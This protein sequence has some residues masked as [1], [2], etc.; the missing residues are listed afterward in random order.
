MSRPLFDGFPP[1][2]SDAWAELVLKDLKGGDPEKLLKTRTEDGLVIQAISRREHLPETLPG[3]L[4]SAGPDGSPNGWVNR[5]EIREKD[6]AAANNHAKTCL[7]RGAEELAWY[8]FPISSGSL[9][10]EA[11]ARLTAGVHLEMVPVHWLAGPLA[12]QTALLLIQEAERRGILPEKLT[13]S[14]DLDP[15][16]DIGAAW[17]DGDLDAWEDDWQKVLDLLETRL[18]GMRTLC[19]RGSMFGKAGA[20]EIQELAFSL[21][22][23]DEYL[24]RL[25]EGRRQEIAARAEVR[26]SVTNRFLVEAARLRASRVLLANLFAAHGVEGHPAIHCVTTSVTKTLY[27]PHN[28]LLRA[29]LEAMSAVLGGCDSLTVAA[30]DQGYESPDEFSEH[31]ARNTMTL[32]RDEAGLNKVADPLAGAY[33]LE[34]LTR[35]VG[36][37]AWALFGQIRDAGG[38]VAAW[39]SGL[40]PNLLAESRQAKVKAAGRRQAP[41]VGTSVYPN[42]KERR[43]AEAS[44]PSSLARM[45][46]RDRFDLDRVT[47]KGTGDWA[48]PG[49][50]VGD[51]PLNPFR[52]SWPFEHLRLKAERHAA[53]GR[54]M[55]K[56]VLLLTGDRTM[57]NARAGFCR[58]FLQSGGLEVTEVAVTD[59]TA[60]AG[61]EADLLILCSSDAEYAAALADLKA[62]GA[63]AP[64]WIAGSPADADALREAGAEDF[65]HIR[66]DVPT[67]ILKLQDRFDIAELPLQGPL[68]PTKK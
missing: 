54:P 44:A 6:L 46:L 51:S 3:P 65:I 67:T 21:A 12:P 10:A 52:P 16:M 56:I 30:Y 23:L 40:I 11:F 68:D 45:S 59:W 33:E 7:M 25:P 24:S 35:E 32:L 31:L 15:I 1:V 2:S 8:L 43:L 22:L 55:P 38:F 28:N 47:R 57:R 9:D 20:T 42:P 17:T 61:I 19:I 13:G 37:A 62:A 5:E 4:R 27:D 49:S 39:K 14:L 41:I 66:L 50:V 18:T 58:G 34:R 29:T 48:I 36:E 64:I 60:A 63:S 53:L 26:F